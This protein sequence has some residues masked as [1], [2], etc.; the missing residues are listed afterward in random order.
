M[1]FSLAN[2]AVMQN[3]DVEYV[4]TVFKFTFAV[5]SPDRRSGPHAAVGA[6]RPRRA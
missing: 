4:N 1:L 5:R 2:A 3:D 6:A